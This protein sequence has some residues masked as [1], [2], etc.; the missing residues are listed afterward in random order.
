MKKIS[1]NEDEKNKRF[2]SKKKTL[3]EYLR[4]QKKVPVLSSVFLLIRGNLQ[5]E[6][7]LSAIHVI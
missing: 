6:K 4:A 3:M 1:V 5:Q 2:F 7:I